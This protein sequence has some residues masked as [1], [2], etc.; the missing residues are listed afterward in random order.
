[1]NKKKL[2]LII[3]VISGFM[4]VIAFMTFIV[5]GANIEEIDIEEKSI[6][7][8]IDGD[9]NVNKYDIYSVFVTSEYS[10]KDV[11][12]SI[13]KDDWEYFFEDCDALFNEDGWNYIGYF[14]PDFD[15]NIEIDS[16]QQI[17]IINDDIYFDEGG[18]EIIISLL[19]CCLG[20]LGVIISIIMILSSSNKATFMDN[21]QEIVIINPEVSEVVMNGDVET[22]K[23]P[24]WWE[25]SDEKKL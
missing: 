22:E 19:F 10:C 1:M 8:G 13:Y 7:K 24:E 14:S 23:T 4:V 3:L 12:L 6:F 25:I 11:E 15:G 20:F 16:N 2:G 17:L 21:K 5:G 9:I 18:F